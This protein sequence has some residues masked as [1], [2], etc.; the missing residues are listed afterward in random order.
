VE[1]RNTYFLLNNNLA[2]HAGKY[3]R[4]N[5]VIMQLFSQPEKLSQMKHAQELY[6]K[7][8]SAKITGD[9]II[10]LIN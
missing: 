7:R 3:A 5:D 6:G 10:R 9:F 8:H 1:N 4:I 2:V